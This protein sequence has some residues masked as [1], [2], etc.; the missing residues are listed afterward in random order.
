KF[1]VSRKAR[2]MVSQDDVGRGHRQQLD[3]SSNLVDLLVG[4]PGIAGTEVSLPLRE[5]VDAG[6]AARRE[7]G[8]ADFRVRCMI[9]RKPLLIQ[10]RGESRAGTLNRDTVVRSFPAGARGNCQGE[11]HEQEADGSA[12]HDLYSSS[13]EKR[14]QAPW[15]PGQTNSRN[16][17]KN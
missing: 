14:Q 15:I 9:I 4:H 3:S 8:D 16:S 5:Q 7:V 11:G 1:E 12:R 6:T 2:Q 10:R 17:R 13:K